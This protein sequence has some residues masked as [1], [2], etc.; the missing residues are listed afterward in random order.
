LS[1]FY[2]F[3]GNTVASDGPG[4]QLCRTWNLRA[5]WGHLISSNLQLSSHENLFQKRCIFCICTSSS[6]NN[7][8]NLSTATCFCFSLFQ[9]PDGCQA[10]WEINS[11][12]QFPH[13]APIQ[14]LEKLLFVLLARSSSPPLLRFPM[15]NSK[16][17]VTEIKSP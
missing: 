16:S 10:P 4:K 17:K 15:E 11:L 14:N 12:V 5:C 13:C 7:R 9:W 6:D 3:K 8:I 1:W 2:R